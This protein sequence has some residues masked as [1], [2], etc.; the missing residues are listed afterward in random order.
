MQHTGTLAQLSHKCR[1]GYTFSFFFAFICTHF[2]PPRVIGSVFFLAVGSL[3]LWSQ[4]CFLLPLHLL[5][6]L[7]LQFPSHDVITLI[8]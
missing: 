3:F 5:P 2:I 4:R 1:R 6:D 8:A 7:R